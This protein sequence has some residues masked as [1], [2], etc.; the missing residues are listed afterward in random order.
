[1]FNVIQDT[2]EQKPLE[3]THAKIDQVICKKL[4]T[5]DYSIEGLEDTL[6]IERKGSVSEFYGNITE[7]RFWNEME[8]M[9]H[10]KY[11]FFLLE[12]GPSQIEMFPHGSGLPKKVIN[13][14]KISSA[15][16]MKCITKIQIEYDIHVI[17]GGNRDNSL[18]LIQNIM[19]AVNDKET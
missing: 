5:G 11:K 9:R 2:R 19:K 8:R 6:C 10:F 18:Y 7:K 13:R 3:F 16:L 12:F 1:M 17:F 4:D 15:Y 14:L